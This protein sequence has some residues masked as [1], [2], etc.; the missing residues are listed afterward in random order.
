MAGPYLYYAQGDE[1]VRVTAD[2][3]EQN[4]SIS[5][6]QC[7]DIW[8]DVV[9]TVTSTNNRH[10]SRTQ[11]RGFRFRGPIEFIDVFTDRPRLSNQTWYPHV[12]IK[13]GQS[14]FNDGTPANGRIIR[15]GFT[16]VRESDGRTF[17]ANGYTSW[18][19]NN[20][21]FSDPPTSTIDNVQIIP[22]DGAVDDCGDGGCTTTFYLNG[23]VSLTLD[24][25]PEV[26]G[27]GDC[28]DC[29]CSLV[30][31]LRSIRV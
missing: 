29:M 16:R 3:Y 4:S 9:V 15:A 22:R 12:I 17:A 27:D 30:P 25:C 31:I 24:Y 23:E 21:F 1:W 2:A 28:S 14:F 13:A 10:G 19:F 6:G 7:D 8:Y 11:T 18:T 5:G 20:A 26:T